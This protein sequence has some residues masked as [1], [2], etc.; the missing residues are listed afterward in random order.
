MANAE[1]YATIAELQGRLTTRISAESAVSSALAAASRAIEGHCN[2][3]FTLDA[4]ASSRTYTPARSDELL[5]DDIGTLTDLVV[6]IGSDGVS[7]PNVLTD[8]WSAPANAITKGRPIELLLTDGLFPV[9]RITQQR[10]LSRE[11]SRPTV[12]V[13]ARWGWPSV[14]E[15]VSEAV[16]LLASRLYVRRDSPTGVAGFGDMGVV[17]VSSQDSD[18][19][20]MLAPYARSL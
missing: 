6:A 5:V 16:L 18:V 19:K 9:L 3:V 7:F 15:D 2:R 20:A 8:Y 17:R 1:R 11:V 13:T 4:V 10:T 12:Q 14:P